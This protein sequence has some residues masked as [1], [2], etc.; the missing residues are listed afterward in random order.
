MKL[1][2]V[3]RI[4][5]IITD[6]A[7]NG[8]V[9]RSSVV[10]PESPQTVRHRRTV[11]MAATGVA[12]TIF[13]T[14]LAIVRRKKEIDT[15]VTVTLRMQRRQHP[16]LT[17]FMTLVSWLGFQPQSLVLP[18]AVV[19]GSWLL[20]LRRDARYLVAAWGASFF[21]YTTKRFVSRPRPNGLNITVAQANLRDSSFPSGH[22]LHYV[23]FWGFVTYLWS[24]RIRNRWLRWGPIAWMLGMIGMVGP[25]RIY[26]GHH[27]L[28]DVLAS[29]SLGT[30]LLMSL[31]GLRQRHGRRRE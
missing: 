20:G 27:W 28:T 10:P 12:F 17:R 4:E 11:F 18:G 7:P 16:L 2:A 15:D 23:V 6:A 19:A 26:L 21:S 3:Q 5:K 30:G 24:T 9:R 13:L 31:I 22:V 8:R 25:S 1:H 14:L 29:Y